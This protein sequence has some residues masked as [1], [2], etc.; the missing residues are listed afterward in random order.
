MSFPPPA[1][2]PDPEIKPESP[3]LQAVSLFA[4][5]SR[6]HYLRNGTIMGEIEEKQDEEE[7]RFGMQVFGIQNSYTFMSMLYLYKKVR[8]EF[9]QVLGEKHYYY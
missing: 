7:E 2:L 4:E 5:P 6:K 3:A 9:Y 8:S 1:D